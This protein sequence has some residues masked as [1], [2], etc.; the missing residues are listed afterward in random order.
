MKRILQSAVLAAV[1]CGAV[2]AD[3]ELD[4]ALA[5]LKKKARR[6]TYSGRAQLQ[7]Q[8]LTV[9]S[10]QAEKEKLLDSKLQV[11]ERKL[12][13]EAP[14]RRPRPMMRPLPRREKPQN[15]LTPALLDEDAM[16]ED[17]ENSQDSWIAT[18]LERRKS[19][20]LENEALEKEQKLVDQRVNNELIKG[21]S[22]SFSP[23]GSYNRSLQDII[24]GR[25]AEKQEPTP[26]QRYSPPVTDRNPFTLGEDSTPPLFTPTFGQK[27]SK[28]GAAPAPAE[29]KTFGVEYKPLNTPSD[30]RS[31]WKHNTPEPQAPLKKLRKSTLDADPFADDFMPR[32]NKSIWD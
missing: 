27:P 26:A 22:P 17:P 1:L 14:I 2:A 5:E 12:Q 21:V 31:K 7:D 10:D 23:A 9:P 29:T 3:D 18:E 16:A 28:H 19:L 13:A 24:A 8:G 11:M 30:F 4:A 32:I 20:Q 6:R 15:W 25:P